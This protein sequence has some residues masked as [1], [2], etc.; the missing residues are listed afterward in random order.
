MEGADPA[1][2]EFETQALLDQVHSR[3][4]S[5]PPSHLICSSVGKDVQIP[6]STPTLPEV[7]VQTPA[8]LIEQ[9]QPIPEDGIPEGWTA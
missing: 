6:A 3:R 2:R 9:G 5:A 4:T 7:E 1:E 8:P